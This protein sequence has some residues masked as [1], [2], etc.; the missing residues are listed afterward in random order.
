MALRAII[1]DDEPLARRRIRRLL[2]TD[3]DITVVGEIGDAR[4]AVAAIAD[5]DPDL[6][7]L[8]V[9][10]P[11]HDGFWVIDQ[12][13]IESMPFVLFVTA[14]D[15]HAVR[16]FEVEA[17]DYVVKPFTNDRFHAALARA[18][19]VAVAR[20]AL[21][22]WRDALARS[23]PA[24]AANDRLTVR[25]GDRSGRCSN[26]RSFRARRSARMPRPTDR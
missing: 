11:E 6:V 9:E 2:E 13:G 21:A 23:H 15:S 14:H 16:A 10:L 8:D 25:Q 19:H 5:H 22:Q 4:N 7:F 3:A 26:L 1:V 18:K 12:I 17:I 24:R 20:E